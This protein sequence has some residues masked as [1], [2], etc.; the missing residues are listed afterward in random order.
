[1]VE[2]QN[3]NISNNI[4]VSSHYLNVEQ[5]D[6]K[7]YFDIFINW[8]VTVHL[9][10]F[11]SYPP[12]SLE[13][14]KEQAEDLE[15]LLVRL[16][17]LSPNSRHMVFREILEQAFENIVCAWLTIR[18]G[19]IWWLKKKKV[20]LILFGILTNSYMVWHIVHCKSECCP[21]LF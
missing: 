6:L 10:G 4:T 8:S 1:M 18:M 12:G 11:L 3:I 15:M 13:I 16:L 5:R 7:L 2:G 20:L 21:E 9:S 19:V 14:H 17:Q